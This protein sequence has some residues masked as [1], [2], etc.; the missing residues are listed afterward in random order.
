MSS[1]RGHNHEQLDMP[2]DAYVP[3]ERVIGAL[4]A[5]ERA[6]E[7]LDTEP[8]FAFE[9]PPPEDRPEP[10]PPTSQDELEELLAEVHA[11]AKP[12]RETVETFQLAA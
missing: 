12:A 5:A 4:D 10:S 7:W 6:R 11:L 1:E 8:D 2:T 3:T 9:T